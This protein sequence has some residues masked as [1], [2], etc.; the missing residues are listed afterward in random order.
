MIRL[1]LVGCGR[2]SKKHFEAIRNNSDSFKLTAV[3]D[4]IPERAKEAGESQG[5]PYY[6][7]YEEMLDKEGENIDMVVICTPSGLHPVQ[8]I[9]AA[10]RGLH[11]LTE[12]P[13]AIRL[14]DAEKLIETCDRHKV[15]LFVVK[16][17][18]LNPTIQLLKRAIDKGRFGRIYFVEVN[19]FWTRPQSYYDM[20][21]WR[22]TWEFDGGAF[23]NQASH[24]V[25]LAYYLVG[26]VESVVAFTGTLARRIEAEDTGSAVLRFRNGAIGSI[27][28][29]VLTYPK[30]FEGSITI[31]GEKGTVKV[32]G[33]AVNK[34]EHW[35]FS[36]YDDDD[37][38]VDR[39]N[40][41]TQSVYGF[42]HNLYYRNVADALE[43]GKDPLID[44]REG[45][46]SLEIILAIYRSSRE[47][48]RISLPLKI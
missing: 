32:G 35:E 19:V 6:A 44:G 2:I 46:K 48:R 3:C 45:K 26:E 27:N 13:M 36:D 23:L 5:V 18:R 42:G 41:E 29:T 9:M 10:E 11:V 31:I 15:K 30:N 14:E 39:V 4:I 20:A 21:R 7:D 24:Y 28:V 1:A 37:K 25:D 22:G 12:K 40:Y 38:L 33:I 16:Q 34:I 8:G 17:N 43:N 47:G